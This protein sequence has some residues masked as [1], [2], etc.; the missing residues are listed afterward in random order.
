MSAIRNLPHSRL[1]TDR[2]PVDRPGGS[3]PEPDPAVAGLAARIDR[4]DALIWDAAR[5]GDDPQLAVG[6]AREYAEGVFVGLVL[7]AGSGTHRLNCSVPTPSGP[8]TADEDLRFEVADDIRTVSLPASGAE[9]EVCELFALAHV[10]RSEATAILRT[11]PLS[12]NADFGDTFGLGSGFGHG[13]QGGH[14]SASEG[15]VVRGWRLAASETAPIDAAGMFAFCC[16]EASSG[17]PLPLD[18]NTRYAD[19]R[20]LVTP[21]RP[22]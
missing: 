14:G 5:V 1:A 17:E 10:S 9:R 6:R 7:G 18:P 11:R 13:G 22:G 20:A 21:P 19:A 3:G 16:S 12:A 4:L 2:P 8:V 15:Y